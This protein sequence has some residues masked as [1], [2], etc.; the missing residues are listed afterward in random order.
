MI[1]R[2]GESI[3]HP[4]LHVRAGCPQEACDFESVRDRLADPRLAA[5]GVAIQAHRI[6]L[7]A[8][9][10]DGRPHRGRRRGGFVADQHCC[11]WP[12]SRPPLPAAPEG[13]PLRQP[14]GAKGRHNLA[15]R[16]AHRPGSTR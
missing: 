10:V 8:V 15:R 6:P 1:Q 7:L 12:F 9:P 14:L 11:F 13:H 5:V 16:A 3:F 4:S 2:L